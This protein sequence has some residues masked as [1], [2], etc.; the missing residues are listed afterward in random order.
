M[1]AQ[2]PSTHGVVTSPRG[3]LSTCCCACAR[4]CTPVFKHT[5]T[6]MSNT[7]DMC[8][9]IPPHRAIAP[10]CP[11]FLHRHHQALQ[12][13]K[14]PRAAAARALLYTGEA[15][16][17]IVSSKV[18]MHEG[19]DSGAEEADPEPRARVARGGVVCQAD[20]QVGG[21]GAGSGGG[22]GGAGWARVTRED[23]G[24]G[25]LK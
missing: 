13:L 24:G 23:Q 11:H 18:L 25:Q 15:Y 19:S 9:D 16:A 4:P 6:L 2:V 1:F 22:V 21:R 20:R 7:I 5:S 12:A 10:H 14:A 8:F 17:I 3:H